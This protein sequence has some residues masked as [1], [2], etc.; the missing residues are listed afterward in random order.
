MG[1][2]V[3][4]SLY[5]M[6]LSSL[7]NRYNHTLMNPAEFAQLLNRELCQIVRDESFAT[8][9]CGVLDAARKSVRVV[10]AG[11]PPLVMVRSDGRTELVEAT[12]LPFGFAGVAEYDEFEFRC[13]PGDCL[14]MFTDGAIEIH[15]AA[16]TMLGT[17]G[18]I[19]IL[20]SLGYPESGI[21]IESLQEALLCYSNGIR[22]EDDLT[23]LE[24]RF[25]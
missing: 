18:L 23:L 13:A 14:L 4:A 6:Y 7:W 9:L 5:T 20:N 16:G 10:S 3:A 24:V 22:L 11:G 2:G 17:E 15:D 21:R 1:H 8:A 25:A 12:G 19:G